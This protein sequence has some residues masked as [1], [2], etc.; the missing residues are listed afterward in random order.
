MPWWLRVLSA[1]LC[2]WERNSKGDSWFD[3]FS[4]AALKTLKNAIHQQHESELC[5]FSFVFLRDSQR[6]IQLSTTEGQL[7]L[8]FSSC[9]RLPGCYPLIWSADPGP[10]CVSGE[11]NLSCCE[12]QSHIDP[13]WCCLVAFQINYRTTIIH[14]WSHEIPWVFEFSIVSFIC[15]GVM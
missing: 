4:V 13:K 15:L 14:L 5:A 1:S 10:S 11:K 9:V 7:T 8:A 3:Q 2:R 12:G 6:C